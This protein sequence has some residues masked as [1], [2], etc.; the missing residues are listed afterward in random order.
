MNNC[1]SFFFISFLI[2][3]LYGL[4]LELEGRPQSLIISES[5]KKISPSPKWHLVEKIKPKFD[6]YHPQ[7]MVKIGDFFYFSTVEILQKTKKIKSKGTKY[8]RTAGKG[9]GYLFQFNRKGVLVRKLF[10]GEGAIYHPGGIDYD[11]ASIW[12]PVA[13][14][15]PGSTSIIYKVN[16]K[17]WE[18]EEAFRVNDHIGGI[19]YN[20]DS[21]TLIGMN[22]DSE[23]F[24]EWTR[25]GKLIRKVPNKYREIA[26]QDC[27]FVPDQ[28]MLCSGV[29]EKRG[30][31]DLFDLRNFNK[32]HGVTEIP[33]TPKKVIM[34]R[35]PMTVERFEN[36]LRYYFLPENRFSTLYVYEIY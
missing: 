31:I 24:Y 4:G 10:L 21:D 1:K 25:E 35:N 22:W 28:N 30:G 12:V 26:Y 13:E 7:G 20:R 6:T 15:R 33:R 34:T 2:I 17:S 8:D 16:P 18:A 3:F 5:F 14:Y 32:I 27:K 9:L 11:G 19:V 36:R 29:K 23:L